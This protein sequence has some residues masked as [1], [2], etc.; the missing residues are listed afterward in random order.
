MHSK[1]K[2]MKPGISALKERPFL[3]LK[4]TRG[5]VNSFAVSRVIL[6]EC[7]AV[8]LAVDDKAIGL[9]RFG[10]KTVK[11]GKQEF[12]LKSEIEGK[13][14]G[15]RRNATTMRATSTFLS[16]SKDDPGEEWP[17]CYKIRPG[18]LSTCARTGAS[19]PTT[20]LAR[21]YPVAKSTNESKHTAKAAQN[22][23]A[24]PSRR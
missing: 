6:L 1:V 12:H 22:L 14:Q 10:P 20:P 23:A 15:P 7:L 24:H 11:G 19:Q 9:I 16:Q 21:S 3:R 13:L 17:Y 5:M 2:G 4:F 8:S 18:P